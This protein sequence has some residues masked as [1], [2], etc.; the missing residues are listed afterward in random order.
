M[1]GYEVN[2]MGIRHSLLDSANLIART[3]FAFNERLPVYYHGHWI[4]LSR[5]CWTTLYTRYESYIAKVIKANLSRGDT[6]WDIGAHVGLYS[7][8]VS[9]IVGPEGSVFAFEPSPDVF[10][11]LRSN[12]QDKNNIQTFQYGI[13]ST[14]GTASFAAQGISSMGSF[15]EEV[16]EISRHHHPTEQIHKVLVTTR[17]IDALLNELRNPSLIKIDVEGFELEVLKGSERLLSEIR[18][19][20]IIEVHPY[21]LMLSSGTEQTL[22][23]RLQHYDY[24]WNVIDRNPNSVYTIVANP[25]G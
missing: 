14:E 17:K 7:L 4:W 24:D 13:G 22:F 16:T 9:K 3:G 6:F 1:A 10:L 2:S 15:V 25:Q 23:D 5:R 11:L 20:L 21:Q 8:F 18:P 19:I 12:T